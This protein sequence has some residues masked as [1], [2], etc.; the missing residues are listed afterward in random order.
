A[1]KIAE[2]L[3]SLRAQV[4]E[5]VFPPDKPVKA[6]SLVRCCKD[7]EQYLAYGG[8]P[9]SAGDWDWHGMELVFYEDKNKKDDSLRVLYHEGFHQFIHYSVGGKMDP[10]SWFNE[11]TGDYFFGFNYVGGKWVRGVNSWRRDLAKATKKAH[12]FP[13]LREWLRWN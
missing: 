8:D 6:V 3:E 9:S 5:I 12:N 2:Q 11:G 10:H 4:Y 13:E 1:K 7:R